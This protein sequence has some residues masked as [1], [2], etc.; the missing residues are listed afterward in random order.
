MLFIVIGFP[1]SVLIH[2][3]GHVLGAKLTGHNI[4]YVQIWPGYYLFPGFG[5]KVE[6]TWS[7]GGIAMMQPSAA[8]IIDPDISEDEM[9]ALLKPKWAII[10]LMGTVTTWLISLIFL[11]I[12]YFY[13]PKG[14]FLYITICSSLFYYDILS[15]VVFP[16][17]FGMSSHLIFY[18]GDSSEPIEAL[19]T[20]G[21]PPN[22]SA[23]VITVICIIQTVL[24]IFCIQK[25]NVSV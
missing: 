7:K 1:V 9:L 24:L 6:S 5:K 25:R 21:F 17:F 3:S 10:A 11:L 15:Y 13:R 12:L 18:G 22:I 23:I 2:E 8:N 16:H 4:E 14:V 19:L 20:L